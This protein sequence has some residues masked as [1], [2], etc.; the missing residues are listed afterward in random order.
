M[1]DAA[2]LLGFAFANADFLFEVDGTGKIQFSAGAGTDII[3]TDRVVGESSSRLFQPPG[4]SV[5]ES[6]VRTLRPGSRASLRLTLANGKQANVTMF[7]LPDNGD[8]I[9]CTISGSDGPTPM[10]STTNDAATGLATREAFI[11]AAAGS[12]SPDDTLTLVNLPSLPQVC[13]R[14]PTEQ[15]RSLLEALGRTLASSGARMAGRISQTSFGA[16]ANANNAPTSHVARVRA[17]FAEQGLAQT[18]IEETL[19]SMK[20]RDLSPEQRLMA[21]RYV[22]EKFADS[23]CAVG[24]GDDLS[25]VFTGMMAETE[26]RARE[27]T[28]KVADGGFEIVYQPIKNLATGELSHFEA[29]ARFGSGVTAETIQFVEAM[30]IANAFDLAVAVKVFNVLETDKSHAACVAFNVS[31]YTVQSSSSFAMLAGLLARK[32]RLAPRVLIEV[33]ETAQITDL[34]SA[35]KAID[36]MRKLGYRVGLDDF[37]AGAATLNYLHAFA[38]DFVKFDGSLVKKLG[39][40]KR[41]DMLLA[42]MLKLCGELGV[43]TIAECLENDEDIRRAREA[44]FHDG[45]GYA[46]GSPGKIPAGTGMAGKGPVGKRKGV[47]EYWG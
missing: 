29:L 36:A 14:L 9:S 11:D 23:D 24:A 21:L 28:D 20:G 13:A 35:A 22:V 40:S 3:G 39:A 2:R 46:L 26:R 30:G 17:L 41:D 47:V 10:G 25:G 34:D 31:G 16:I 19:V 4:S 8:R 38:V 12:A 27:L 45:Q 15:S 44:G 33:T 1:S 32:R 6:T 42:A 7:R 5:F 37:G 43:T 18:K